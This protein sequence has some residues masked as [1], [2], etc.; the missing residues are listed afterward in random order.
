L[1]EA[2]F[3]SIQKFHSSSSLESKVNMAEGSNNSSLDNFVWSD[4]PSLFVEEG[5][6]QAALD[7]LRDNSKRQLAYHDSQLNLLHQ[8]IN[9]HRAQIDYWNNLLQQ[10]TN[11]TIPK[12]QPII[13]APVAAVISQPPPPQQQL[14]NSVQQS[15]LA[16]NLAQQQQ[17]SQPL[18]PQGLS[19]LPQA[20]PAAN[21]SSPSQQSAPRLTGAAARNA[22][23]KPSASVALPNMNFPNMALP[24]AGQPG[25]NPRTG[26][27]IPIPT[28]PPP[29]ANGPIN[30]AIPQIKPHEQQQ[31]NQP[32]LGGSL[33][34][35][36]QLGNSVSSN[37]GAPAD[38]NPPGPASPRNAFAA[39][40]AQMAAKLGNQ[41]P[42]MQMA[43]PQPQNKPAPVSATMPTNFNSAL[44]QQG[45][46]WGQPQQQQQQPLQQFPPGKA[47]ISHISYQYSQFFALY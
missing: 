44:Q 31:P 11:V 19:N 27:P 29:E 3:H 12:L 28:L 1:T 10:T 16:M 5:D 38:S 34:S 33:M 39:L 26:Q 40:Q 18:Q 2:Q 25:I 30:P 37:R 46:D 9:H 21:E 14:P 35:N 45:A 42:M 23:V 17:Q 41:P 47:A 15:N 6:G 43:A 24:F 7:W 8:Q 36:P 4:I 22:G 32:Q 20:S 13:A